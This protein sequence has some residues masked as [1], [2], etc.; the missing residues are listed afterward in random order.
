MSTAKSGPDK[1]LLALPHDL[2]S[3]R[4]GSLVAGYYLKE[5]LLA[6]FKDLEAVANDICVVNKDILADFLAYEA[7]AAL[8]IPPFD[9]PASH[10]EHS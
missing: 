9:L 6:R 7:K 3:F 4:L 8:V 5:D 2:N 1:I 10:I